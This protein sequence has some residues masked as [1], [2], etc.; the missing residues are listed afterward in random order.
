MLADL[1]LTRLTLSW[2]QL[3]CLQTEPSRGWLP[4][5]AAVAFNSTTTGF[6]STLFSP[7]LPP[8]YL[9]LSYQETKEN[10]NVI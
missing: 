5:V 2:E 4:L 3:L 10:Q 6:T 9:A 1:H 8:L 7:Y